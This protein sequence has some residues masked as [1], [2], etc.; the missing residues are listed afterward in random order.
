MIRA[1]LA[2]LTLLPV[3]STYG[4]SIR[5]SRCNLKSYIQQNELAPF[6]LYSILNRC[7]TS[8]ALYHNLLQLSHGNTTLDNFKQSKYDYILDSKY[9]TNEKLTTENKYKDYNM[10]FQSYEEHMQNKNKHFEKLFE[11]YKDSTYKTYIL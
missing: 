11:M 2:F 8:I 10:F 6:T 3:S 9:G 7:T 4:P 1:I 5:S